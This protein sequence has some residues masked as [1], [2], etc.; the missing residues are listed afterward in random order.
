M[1]KKYKRRTDAEASVNSLI[2]TIQEE[3]QR[4]GFSL[5]SG[6]ALSLVSNAKQALMKQ[7]EEHYEFYDC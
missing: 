4:A 6:L 2:S 7:L 1:G 3:A 5:S